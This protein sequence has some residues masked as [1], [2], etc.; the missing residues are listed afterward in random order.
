M[1]T[2]E[3][4]RTGAAFHSSLG[5]NDF[6]GLR[7]GARGALEIVYDN[8]A[9]QRMIWQVPASACARRIREALSAAVDQRRVVP[10]L[11]AEL[12]KR[13]IAIEAIAA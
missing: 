6:L 4:G 3:L 12:S 5:R 2:A 13:A 8:G 9:D 1:I 7:Q 11:Y 10:A